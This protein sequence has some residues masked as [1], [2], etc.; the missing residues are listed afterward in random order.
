[1]AT[2]AQQARTK[3]ANAIYSGRLERECCERC[4]S[5]ENIHAH[6]DDYTKPLDVRWLCASCHK[7][8]HLRLAGKTADQLGILRRQQ[9]EKANGQV[10]LEVDREERADHAP[11]VGPAGQLARQH[12]AAEKEGEVTAPKRQRKA[13]A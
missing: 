3:V 1:M 6:H 5:G 12:L 8:H 13:A 2:L 9:Q 4:G 11:Q 7:Q 10:I